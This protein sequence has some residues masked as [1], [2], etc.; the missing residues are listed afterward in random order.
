MAETETNPSPGSS[1]KRGLDCGQFK[2]D[3]ELLFLF[4]PVGNASECLVCNKVVSTM[5]KYHL[6][7]HY[8]TYHQDEFGT[9]NGVD[10]ETLLQRLKAERALEASNVSFSSFII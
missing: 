5:R 8:K 7:R 10:R 6:E 3:W 4:I 1:K 2:P 9:T